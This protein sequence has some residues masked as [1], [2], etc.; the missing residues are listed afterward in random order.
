MHQWVGDVSS[1][2]LTLYF[3]PLDWRSMEYSTLYTRVQRS[4]L[5]P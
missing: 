5:T 2:V 4:S 3:I 1:K